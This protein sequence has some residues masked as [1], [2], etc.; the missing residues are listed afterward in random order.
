MMRSL[1]FVP[2]DGGQ[3]PYEVYRQAAA[4][5]CYAPPSALGSLAVLR[6]R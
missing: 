1:L 2:A 6:R 4:S 5:G 3:A